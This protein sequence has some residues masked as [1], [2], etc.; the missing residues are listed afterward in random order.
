MISLLPYAPNPPNSSA[1]PSSSGYPPVSH[2]IQP[3]LSLQIPLAVPFISAVQYHM[4]YNILYK[5]GAMNIEKA[6]GEGQLL[7]MGSVV[8]GTLETAS[9]AQWP[10]LWL[11]TPVMY[12]LLLQ[13]TVGNWAWGGGLGSHW[14][15]DDTQIPTC[16]SSS[17]LFPTARHRDCHPKPGELS[18]VDE[19]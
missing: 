3:T 14:G 5:A 6:L 12:V 8:R 19:I 1:L 10:L 15:G 9:S 13:G 4:G 18:G 2:G 16:Y 11:G 17:L 7:E